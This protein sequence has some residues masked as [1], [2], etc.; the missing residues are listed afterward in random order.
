MDNEIQ[1]LKIG[2]KNK[3]QLII[4]F[5]I[6]LIAILI[7]GISI[8]F[9]ASQSK[10]KEIKSLQEQ[11]KNFKNNQI[12]KQENQKLGIKE[13]FNKNL[14]LI[15]Y[16]NY[17]WDP[18][19]SIEE[20]FIIS[21]DPKTGEQK[22]LVAMG[23]IQAYLGFAIFENKVFFTA[24]NKI[25]VLDIKSG[26][27][28]FLEIPSMNNGQYGSLSSFLLS[29]NKI[30]YLLS[31]EY[32]YYD[33]RVY[34]MV[35]GEDRII[36]NNLLH[37]QIKA[38][39]IGGLELFGYESTRNVLR[40]HLTAVD[41]GVG[42]RIFDFDLNNGEVIEVGDGGYF[43]CEE[44]PEEAKMAIKECEEENKR[45]KESTTLKINCN[46][47]TIDREWRGGLKIIT[48]DKSQINLGDN[49]FYIGCITKE[50]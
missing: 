16:R 23:D 30:F 26:S 27:Q 11:T 29:D 28:S 25:E 33:L 46:G 49:F 6:V 12:K 35:T 14:I 4:V 9:F 17:F 44:Y 41:I 19:E 50:E 18:E 22:P 39:G 36:F 47:A 21:L 15:A 10:D 5:F 7:T 13:A 32:S 38:M 3:K 48:S 37:E 45:F 31:N 40:I 20:V 8:L 43:S 1:P 34:D 24:P 2:L 42:L